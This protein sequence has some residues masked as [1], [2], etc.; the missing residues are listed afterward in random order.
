MSLSLDR[1][2]FLVGTTGLALSRPV[3]ARPYVLEAS[4]LGQLLKTGDGRVAFEYLTAKPAGLTAESAC[5]FHPIT[6]P[7]GERISDLAPKD[8][9]THRGVFLAWHAMEFLQPGPVRA[10]FW[11]WG[12]FAPTAG[13]VITNRD[14][15]LA[16][17]DAGGATIEIQNDWTIDGKRVIA[18]RTTGVWR[19]ATDVNVLDLTF[20][21]TPDV[22]AT[23]D[24]QAFGGFCARGRNDG[25]SWF[26]N[27]AGPVDLPNSSAGNAALNWPAAPWYA[28]S[29]AL[30]S[31]RTIGWA[32]VDHP[33]NPPSTWHTPRSVHFLQPAIM[34]GAPVTLSR[35]RT[36]T[37]RYLVAA[38][39]GDVPVDRL[40]RLSSEW[41][42]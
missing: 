12:R 31:G 6:T 27:A 5:C 1:R 32:V 2:E 4:P 37:L 9:T 38:F 16:A 17:A 36:L 23:I 14:L 25:K 29:I 39:D 11:G 15:R 34:A 24:Q 8:H 19:G 20:R 3:Q 41:R 40:N 26:S 13:R 28:Y 35:G 33:S 10:D 30:T 7:S 18:E 21:L 22:D 42:R